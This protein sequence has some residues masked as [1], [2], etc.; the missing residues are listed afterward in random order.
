MDKFENST[1][2]QL[3]YRVNMVSND[4]IKMIIYNKNKR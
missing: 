1:I 2:W 3:N 4:D